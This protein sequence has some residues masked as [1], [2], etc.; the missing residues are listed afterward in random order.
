MPGTVGGAN[1]T[2]RVRENP[3]VF[4]RKRAPLLSG[5]A[6]MVAQERI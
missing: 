1:W 3:E 6:A 4:A 2:Y 5:F